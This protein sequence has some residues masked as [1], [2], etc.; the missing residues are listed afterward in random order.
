MS[1]LFRWFL[2]ALRFSAT[3][4]GIKQTLM[5]STGTCRLK[6]Y[7]RNHIF[8]KS[9][10]KYEILN[11]LYFG[12]SFVFWRAALGQFRRCIFRRRS[13]MVA[14]IFISKMDQSM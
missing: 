9:N 5:I 4:S 12:S 3:N 10:Y 14:K 2:L 11:H 1:D 6:L 13:T 8:R 7:T